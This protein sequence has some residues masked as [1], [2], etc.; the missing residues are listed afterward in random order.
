MYIYKLMKT[1]QTTTIKFPEIKLTARDAHKLRGYFGNLFSDYS[2]LLHNHT[3]DGKLRYAYPLVQYKVVKGMPVLVGIGEGAELL[4]SLFL[5]IKEID[6]EG[7]KYP[8]LDKNIEAKLNEI[9]VNS[10][11]FQYNFTT[12]WMALNQHNFEKY[13]SFDV[14]AKKTFM[15][16]QIRNNILSFLKGTGIWVKEEILA[17]A[18]VTEKQTKFKNRHMLAFSGTFTANVTLPDYIGLGKAVSRGFGTIVRKS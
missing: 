4:V 9:T 16:T 1:F 5:K 17:T 10:G 6:I 2:H 3:P 13:C 8:V 18:D 15:N 11:L 14:N 12:L 7:R